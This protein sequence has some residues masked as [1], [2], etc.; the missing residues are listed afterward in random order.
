MLAIKLAQPGRI[1]DV[2]DAYGR[3]EPEDMGEAPSKRDVKAHLERLIFEKY[4]WLYAGKRYMLTRAGE[5][6]VALSGLRLD[7]D[8][9]RLYLL[10]ETRMRSLRSRGDTHDW[11]LKQQP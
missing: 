6:Y 3:L 10:K 4:V 1:A 7:L 9:R 5:R 11:P 8:M 2:E